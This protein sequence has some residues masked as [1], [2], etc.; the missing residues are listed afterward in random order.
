MLR[1]EVGTEDLL[2]SRF[3]LS[4]AFELSGLLGTLEG[5][6]PKRLPRSWSERLL[7]EFRRLRRETDLDAALA[8]HSGTYGADFVV[9]PPTGPDQSWADDL[10]AI[11]ATPPARA[12]EEAA[13]CLARRP[14]SDPRVLDVLRSEDIVERVADALDIAWHTLLA[15]DW[16]RL[17]AICERD[18]VHRAGELTKSGWAAALDGLHPQV[19]WRDGGIDFPG[20]SDP[21]EGRSADRR[22]GDGRSTDSR[23]GDGTA[24]ASIALAGDGLLF[25]PSVFVW[26]G[27]AAHTNDPWPK[28]LIYPAR[29]IAA[30]W[31]GAPPSAGGPLAD[32]LGRSRALLLASLAEPASTTHLARTLGLAPGAVGDHLATLRRAG[33]LRRARSGRSVLYSRT[34]L[35]DALVS[36]V[37]SVSPAPP[38]SLAESPPEPP[39]GPA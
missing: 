10:A 18:I 30:V 33:L 22:S 19:H 20:G 6:W 2:R 39:P 14:V 1:F 13:A 15:P 38:V 28:T 32:L 12:R 37:P 7:P 27:F 5:L 4:P 9:L 3:A 21:A 35:G 29:G 26:P 8:L 36:G 31:A 25:L 17:R 11:R 34:P 23:S 24:P 16:P